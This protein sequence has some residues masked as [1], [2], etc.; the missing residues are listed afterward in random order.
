M[1]LTFGGTTLD[2]SKLTVAAE[3]GIA[4]R[5][6][7]VTQAAMLA[8]LMRDPGTV[9]PWNAFLGARATVRQT[10]QFLQERLRNCGSRLLVQSVRGQGYRL[11]VEDWPTTH[12]YGMAVREPEH[13]RR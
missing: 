8:D 3:P 10:R 11:I 12:R 6:L 13:Q 2:M 1:I 5:R 7:S 9:H 4:P